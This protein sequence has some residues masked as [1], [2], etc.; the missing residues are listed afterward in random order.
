MAIKFG[1]LHNSLSKIALINS[2]Y[3]W[4]IDRQCCGIKQTVTF[5]QFFE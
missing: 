5:E 1:N 2:A 3:V 4:N